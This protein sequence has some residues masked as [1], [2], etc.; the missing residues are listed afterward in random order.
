MFLKK[1]QQYATWGSANKQTL[2][3]ERWLRLLFTGY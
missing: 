1:Q 3:T 2:M